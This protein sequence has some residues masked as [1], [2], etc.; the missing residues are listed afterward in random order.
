MCRMK[1]FDNVYAVIM[2]GGEG[3]RLWPLSSPRRPKQF[4]SV[5]GGKP[6]I[7]HAVDRLEGLIPPQRILVVTASRFVSLTRKALPRVP[8]EN[9]IGEPC[10]RDTAGAAAV[11]CALVKRLGGDDAVGC[12]LPA[13]HLITPESAFRRT[14]KQA[15]A[16]AVSSDSIVT[17]GIRPDRPASEYGYIEC[18]GK[19]EG[20][21][22]TAAERVRRFTEKPDAATAARYLKSG[23]HLWNAG[24]F[25]WRVGTLEAAFASA[26]PDIGTIIRPLAEA[27][28]FASALRR[29]YPGVR[30][31]SFDY[32]VMEKIGN[33]LVVRS[34]FSWDDIG[35]LQALA[36]HLDADA[37][38]NVCIGEA[39]LHDT[40][41]SIAVSDGS[42]PL[43]IAGLDNVI[44]VRSGNA[45]L[46]M[47]KDMAGEM[48]AIVSGLL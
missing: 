30:S 37:N 32:A 45:V 15:V 12:I 42:G 3:R 46:V 44:A 35:S 24:L 16:A 27:H 26:A 11:A 20:G 1:R 39:V 14:L 33:I 31:I 43:V 8:A 29:L 6:L 10:R 28:G 36:R 25:I 38:G 41:S 2:A 4:I 7:R 40:R 13:D 34:G 5:F 47:S 17:I 22:A 18:C 23:R 19:A 21:G 48:K 9:I